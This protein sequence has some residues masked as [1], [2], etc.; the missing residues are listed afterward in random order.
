M[1]KLTS[2]TSCIHG[3]LV[4]SK[5]LLPFVEIFSL[6]IGIKIKQIKKQ[7]LTKSK[8]NKLTLIQKR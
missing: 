4:C 2:A 3:I 6:I 1:R 8:L 7:T 5:T